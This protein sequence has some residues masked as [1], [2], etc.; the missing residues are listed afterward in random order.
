MERDPI[1]RLHV[2]PQNTVWGRHGGLGLLKPNLENEEQDIWAL[3]WFVKVARLSQY[4]KQI[5]KNLE[6]IENMIYE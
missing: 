6:D 5:T 3:L 1:D 4:Q 2:S